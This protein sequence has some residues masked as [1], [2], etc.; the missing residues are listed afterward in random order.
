MPDDVDF[1][2]RLSIAHPIMGADWLEAKKQELAEAPV[3]KLLLREHLDSADCYLEDAIGLLE[4]GDTHA[5]VLVAR[6]AFEDV[7]DSLIAAKRPYCPAR[8]WR[9]RQVSLIAG[10]PLDFEEYWRWETMRD[11]DPAHPDQWVVALVE[12]CRLLMLEVS[13]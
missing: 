10:G 6:L 9:A 12:R 5:A 8:K 1:V 3:A 4:S 13:L 11:L 2:Y 7:V